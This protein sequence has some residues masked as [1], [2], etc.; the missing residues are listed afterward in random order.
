[1]RGPKPA[2]TSNKLVSHTRTAINVFFDLGNNQRLQNTELADRVS[3]LFKGLFIELAARLV[4]INAD[5]FSFNQ[6]NRLLNR[7]VLWRL[8]RVHC[9]IIR[10]KFVFGKKTGYTLKTHYAGVAELADAQDSKPCEGD[11]MRVR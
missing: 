2:L 10:R 8:R 11:L 3:E 4:R 6:K 1:M 9:S 5:L 7:Q